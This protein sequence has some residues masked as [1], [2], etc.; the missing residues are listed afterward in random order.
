[1]TALYE[2]P[3]P[4][5]I[6]QAIARAETRGPFADPNHAFG[7]LVEELVEVLDEVRSGNRERL[8]AELLDLAGAAIKAA[9]QCAR[10]AL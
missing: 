4:D 3:V 5:P 8:R 6:A 10:G 9:R 2:T 7:V 1:V